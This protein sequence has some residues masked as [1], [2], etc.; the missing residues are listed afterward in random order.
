MVHI[1]HI[2]VGSNVVCSTGLGNAKADSE[3]DGRQAV[4]TLLFPL[5]LKSTNPV[6]LGAM[7]QMAFANISYDA[8]EKPTLI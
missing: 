1:Y 3:W 4:P 8:P 5:N 2:G 6:I 7:T